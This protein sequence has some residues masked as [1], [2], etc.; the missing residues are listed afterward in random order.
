MTAVHALLERFA[1]RSTPVAGVP[2][3]HHR[4]GTR[5]ER[6][7]VMGVMT[8]GDEVG[9]L[10]AALHL[11]DE[12]DAGT[13]GYGG[14]LT[15]VVGNPQAGYAGRRFLEA[16]LNRVFLPG[17]PSLERERAAALMPLLD[18]AHLFID[19][20]QTIL[21]TARPFWIFPWSEAGEAWIRAVGEVHAWVTR[22]PS[23]G[24]VAGA[25][26][27][28]E[29]VRARGAPALTVEL[30]VRGLNP[31]QAALAHRIMRRALALNDALADGGSLVD[32]AAAGP[33]QAY[34][35]VHA[36]PYGSPAIRLRE[37]LVNF[38]PVAAGQPLTAPG[39]PEVT[40]PRDGLLLFPKYPPRDAAGGIVGPLPAELYRLVAPL[41]CPPGHHFRRP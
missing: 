4:P 3:S 7:L 24:F 23:E 10:P 41:G 16:D 27:A 32:L 38:Q 9:S 39:S 17:P 37:G 11:L 22:E 25:L 30:G 29:Y 40:A 20:H 36:E 21:P 6:H 34:L 31:A 14:P 15:V 2:W 5:H 28:D 33:P 8:H 12:L 1:A 18:R 35:F 19:F 26:C 13:V